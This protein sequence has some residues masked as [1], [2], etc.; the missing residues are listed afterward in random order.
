MMVVQL[1]TFLAPSKNYFKCF[2]GKGIFT[3]V[4]T[5]LLILFVYFDLNLNDS[6]SMLCYD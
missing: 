4:L 6:Q 5:A 2:H 1:A 3:L